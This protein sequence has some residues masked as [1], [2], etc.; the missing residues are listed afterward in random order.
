MLEV[1]TILLGIA[2]LVTFEPEGAMWYG[3]VAC[4]LYAVECCVRFKGIKSAD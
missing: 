3:Y 1:L 2:G 4:W